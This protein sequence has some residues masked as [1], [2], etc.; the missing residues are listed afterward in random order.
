M[1]GFGPVR[2][3]CMAEMVRS[4]WT[5]TRA[6]L[7]G[8]IPEPTWRR[9]SGCRLARGATRKAHDRLAH[10]GGHHVHWST[11]GSKPQAALLKA[12]KGGLPY[13]L[14]YQSPALIQSLRA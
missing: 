1:S 3:N 8:M 13:P 4:K 11:S 9:G 7:M 6:S 10:E 2:R 5:A 12:L 14:R